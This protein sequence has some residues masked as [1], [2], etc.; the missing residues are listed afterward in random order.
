MENAHPTDDRQVELQHLL[1]LH[2]EAGGKPLNR[3]GGGDPIIVEDR[4]GATDLHA[5]DRHS[6]SGEGGPKEDPAPA[7][8]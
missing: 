6:G 1:D 2:R 3:T 8:Y 7:I 4:F 5:A